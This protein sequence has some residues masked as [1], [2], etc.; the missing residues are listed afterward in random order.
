MPRRRSSCRNTK[1]G[2]ITIRSCPRTSSA[3]SI[4]GIAGFKAGGAACGS[5]RLK[6]REFHHLAPLLGFLGDEPT[7]RG[8]RAGKRLAADFGKLCA[9]RGIAQRSVDL[10]VEVIDDL[11]RRVLRSGD[12]VPLA[13]FV[14]RHKISHLRQ[15]GKTFGACW[16]RHRKRT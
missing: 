2:R 16:A 8:G 12:A 6:P 9:H 5:L 1:L 10:A 11:E 7:E 4:S 15:R 13:R 14:T 3:I